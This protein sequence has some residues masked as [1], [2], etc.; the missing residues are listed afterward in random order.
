M[1]ITIKIKENGPI[2]ISLE[3]AASVV[4]VDA[5]G[6]RLEPTPGKAIVLCRC[7]HSSRKPFCD[8]THRTMGIGAAV[9]APR[10][11]PAAPAAP[12]AHP[13]QAAPSAPAVPAARPATA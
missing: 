6:E 9:A 13:T 3:D 8:S 1:P 5:A 7:G 10:V 4:I 12:P 2:F 11:A